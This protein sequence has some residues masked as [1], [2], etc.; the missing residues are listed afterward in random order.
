M[1]YIIWLRRQIR[2]LWIAINESGSSVFI[3]DRATPIKQGGI[4]AGSTFSDPGIEVVELWRRF[5][6]P[7][8]FPT[9]VAPTSAFSLAESGYRE[10]G[11]IVLLLHF[12]ATFN[13]GSISPAYGT[14][15]FRSGLPNS[16]DYTGVVLPSAVASTSLS[17]AQTIPNYLVLLGNQNWTCIVDYDAGEQPKSSYDNDYSTPLSA[18]SINQK[19]VTIMGVYPTFATTSAIT[20]MTKQSLQSMSAYEQV[21]MVAES[22]S[23][24]QTI[25]IPVAWGTITGL[26]QFNTFSGQWDTISLSDFTQTAVT[27]VI[28]GNTVNYTRYTHN[29]A[30]IGA[31]QL[32]FLT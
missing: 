4:A 22:D 18:G 29:G 19:T 3:D 21:S 8:L 13:R 10:I 6:Y 30:K 23:D 1:N 25:D 12:T 20:T 14:N 32:R 27:N 26:Q 24:K 11:E 15:G 5:L 2:L 17:N 16:Y 31:R 28:Q 9:L 7:E